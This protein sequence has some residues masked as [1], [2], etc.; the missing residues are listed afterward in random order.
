MFK[1]DLLSFR[2]E[3]NNIDKKIVTLLAKRKKLVLNIAQSKIQNNQPIRDINREKNLLDKLTIL[4]KKKNLNPNYI[5]RL[6]ELIIEESV[7]IQSELLEKHQNHKSTNKNIFAFLGPKGSYSYFAAFEYA[8]INFKILIEKEC[9][10]FEEVI[11][12]VLN[13]ESNFAILPIENTCSGPINELFDILKNI[14]LFIVGEVSIHIDHCLLAIKNADLSIIKKIYSHPQP[15]KQC[16]NF[17]DQFPNWTIKHTNSTSDAIKKVI[18]YNQ[19]TNAAL[20]SEIGN[21]IYG[22]KVLSKN[23]SNQKNNIT[24]FICLSKTPAKISYNT[25]VKTTVVF[26]LEKE[27]KELSKII[28]NLKEN[29]KI[30]TI[31]TFYNI[32]YNKKEKIF[33]LDIKES[34]S[35]NITQNIINKIQKITKFIKILGCYPI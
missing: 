30:I 20:G 11:Q 34:L 10:N 24:R 26:F 18:K 5:T 17:I 2:N 33:Y 32:N 9:L 21:Q 28:F 31:L 27:S 23:I 14:N 8:K 15:F 1:N 7:L 19:I 3:I 16:S 4:G 13:D 6:F 29:R 35:S 25:A 12:S 22:L